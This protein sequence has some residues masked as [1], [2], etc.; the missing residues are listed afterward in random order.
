MTRLQTPPADRFRGLP[1]GFG[2]AGGLVLPGLFCLHGQRP[3]ARRGLFLSPHAGR[4]AQSAGGVPVF[5]FVTN[6]RAERDEGPLEERFGTE[7]EEALK[8]GF[9][10]VKIE[11][12][13]A[14]G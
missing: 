1:G 6:R 11:P 13:L 3:A 8:F 10:D 4:T 5:F 12:S 2:G 14:W 7:R 9:F